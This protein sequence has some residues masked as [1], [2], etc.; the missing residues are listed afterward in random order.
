MAEKSLDDQI[1]E[2]ELA[3]KGVEL[4][5]LK[6][7][8]ALTR[9]QLNA[10]WYSGKSLAQITAVALTVVALYSAI[11]QLFL[12][13]IKQ[14]ESRLVQ[15]KAE[16]AQAALDS[17]NIEKKKIAAAIDSLKIRVIISA[18]FGDLDSLSYTNVLKYYKMI[19]TNDYF[20]GRL[21][22]TG[23]A[24]Q[25]EFEVTDIDGDTVIYDAA[26]GLTWQGGNNLPILLWDKAKAYVDTL[27][28]A[29]GH[30]RFPTLREA[31][32]LIEPQ[33]NEQGLYID[34]CFDFAPS[35]WTSDK[36]G[37]DAKPKVWVA[38]FAIGSFF[39]GVDPSEGDFFIP[40]YYVRAVR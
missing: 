10:K 22:H 1:K 8:T 26:T 11:D 35:I 12:K 30:W 4:E 19:K 5:K 25:N 23:K 14:H 16:L 6:A 27:T 24:I 3:I 13:D 34:E 17:L 9:K 21:N 20:D 28:Y 29:G 38:A 37:T 36:Y 2:A 7:E 33:T 39:P 32:S 18:A 31:M 40:S 15:L